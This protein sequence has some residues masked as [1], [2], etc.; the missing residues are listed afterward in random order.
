MLQSHMLHCHLTTDSV[1][2]FLLTQVSD[3]YL[4]GLVLHP[5]APPPPP[6]TAFDLEPNMSRRT[7]QLLPVKS[8]LPPSLS[9]R[10]SPFEARRVC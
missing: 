9:A 10:T 4:L 7:I 5:D 1:C 3:M 8:R 6:P 2:Y